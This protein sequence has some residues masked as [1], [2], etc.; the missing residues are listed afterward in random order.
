MYP[1]NDP[2]NN[3]KFP[4]PK[5]TTDFQ[6]RQDKENLSRKNKSVKNFTEFLIVFV[7]FSKMKL[8]DFL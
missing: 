8:F 7:K 1:L 5:G 6:N 2:Q 4:F 3:V